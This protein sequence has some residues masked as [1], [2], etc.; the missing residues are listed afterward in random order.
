MSQQGIS[1]IASPV[2]HIT[3]LNPTS[4]HQACMS[5]TLDADVSDVI[6]TENILQIVENATYLSKVAVWMQKQ[7]SQSPALTTGF[8]PSCHQ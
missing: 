5:T 6:S 4:L 8:Y 7:S 2:I 1:W 3:S